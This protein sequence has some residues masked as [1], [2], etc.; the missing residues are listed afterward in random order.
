MYKVLIVDDENL[1][2]VAFRTIVDYEAFGFTVCA[3][4][5]DGLE[6]LEICRREDPDLIITDIKM[7]RMD[8]ITMIE[9]LRQEGF[10]GQIILISNY[11]D[12]ELV[13]QGL[14]MGAMD[15]LLKLT[16]SPQ[17]FSTLLVRVKKVLDETARRLRQ[18]EQG[19]QA[20]DK[21]ASQEK[22]SLWRTLLSSP[23]LV[24]ADIPEELFASG[25]K[26]LFLI[27][28]VKY[29]PAM[30]VASQKD[31]ELADYAL[32]N[33]TAEVLG[34]HVCMG[35]LGS[36][37]WFVV[38]EARDR[39]PADFLARK[40]CT[41]LTKYLNITVLILYSVRL[42]A[43]E[44]LLQA[45][46]YS[47]LLPER[48][49]YCQESCAESLE[50]PLVFGAWD[51]NL[52]ELAGQLCALLRRSE[53][54]AA[55]ELVH[56]QMELCR[57]ENVRKNEVIMKWSAAVLRLCEKM[58]GFLQGDAL[59]NG[60]ENRLTQAKTAEQLEQMLTD[61]LEHIAS[62]LQ[63]VHPELPG[64]Q[65]VARVL[66]Y[67]QEH[68]AEKITLAQLARV[69]NFNETYLCTIFR[70]H[71]GTSIFNYI[72]QTRVECA[73]EKLRG[74]DAQ[75]KEIAASLGF[76]DQFYFN[77]MFRK[78]YGI[79]PSEYRKKQDPTNFQ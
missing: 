14:V 16:L 26:S 40:L 28:M 9:T 74:S 50:Q 21:L 51:A 69:V 12:F 41:A 27:R 8:G 39:E 19:K 31:I 13:R 65:E 67:I 2:R 20:M 24:R 78:Y 47:K 1:V 48:M 58:E 43:P 7:P 72:N 46:E 71:M 59:V 73:A 37:D 63:P 6:A 15:Y 45:M 42:S 17:E 53:V 62:L 52:P 23:T 3:T 77:K 55:R 56:Q 75:L 29:G 49:F 18:E 10:S 66:A 79:S 33:I 76:S 25:P 54:P 36:G 11:D 60:G 5:A 22:L 68:L 64:A 4:A 32:S 34:G 38:L 30:S 57:K 61:L 35:T 44:Q 70:S